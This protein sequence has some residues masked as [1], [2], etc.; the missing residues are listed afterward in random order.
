MLLVI[1]VMHLESAP[2]TLSSVISRPYRSWFLEYLYDGSRG[3]RG[4]S[5]A[6]QER[7]NARERPV[8]SFLTSAYSLE[9]I[10]ASGTGDQASPTPATAQGGRLNPSPS[11]PA[12]PSISRS[13][14]R[15]EKHPF[16]YALH[17]RSVRI[18]EGA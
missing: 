15:T 1:A 12:N 6:L 10:C 16:I 18:K 13:L 17:G 5:F 14:I 2:I 9:G 7:A 11:A 3:H 8:A 4:Y